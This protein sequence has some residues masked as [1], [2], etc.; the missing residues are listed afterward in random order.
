MSMR[1]LTNFEIPIATAVVELGLLKSW[2]FSA[3]LESPYGKL[4]EMNTLMIDD[5]TNHSTQS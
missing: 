5:G 4:I 1:P 3:C 2:E